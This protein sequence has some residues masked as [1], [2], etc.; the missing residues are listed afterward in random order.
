LKQK[1]RRKTLLN[2]IFSAKSPPLPFD[3]AIYVIME[4]LLEKIFVEPFIPTLFRPSTT[5]YIKD[6]LE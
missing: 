5:A 1:R 6:E 3:F 2:F 4:Y